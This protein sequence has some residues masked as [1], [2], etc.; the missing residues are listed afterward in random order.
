MSTAASAIHENKVLESSVVLLEHLLVPSTSNTFEMNQAL[1]SAMQH[2]CSVKS[3]PG[4]P[5]WQRLRG[6]TGQSSTPLDAE[7][8]AQS[9]GSSVEVARTRSTKYGLRR[10][11]CQLTDLTSLLLY[12]VICFSLAGCT[13]CVLLQQFECQQPENNYTSRIRQKRH[14]SIISPWSWIT[15]NLGFPRSSG[16]TKSDARTW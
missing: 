16:P 11:D 9:S 15:R 12:R 14:L 7:G 3:R 8:T 1:W 6:Q 13:H 2:H 10:P 4:L 5:D